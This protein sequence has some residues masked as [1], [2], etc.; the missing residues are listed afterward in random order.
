MCNWYECDK[1]NKWRFVPI[2]LGEEDNFECSSHDRAC[3]V[4]DARDTEEV[5]DLEVLEAGM[6]RVKALLSRR[7]RPGKAAEILVQWDGTDPKTGKPWLDEWQPLA[8]VENCG[9]PIP[10]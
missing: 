2:K 5:D 8:N 7:K 1:C 9:L 10:G 4:A 6:Y 3:D